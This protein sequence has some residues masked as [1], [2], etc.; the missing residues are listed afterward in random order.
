MGNF[1][2]SD[3]MDYLIIFIAVSSMLL[4]TAVMFTTE[5]ATALKVAGAFN[6]LNIIS[7]TFSIFRLKNNK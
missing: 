6:I 7:I 3:E 4:L 2:R 5:D 1:I